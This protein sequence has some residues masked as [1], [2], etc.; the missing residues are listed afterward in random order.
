MHDESDPMNE[1]DHNEAMEAD[2]HPK[3]YVII[4]A[5][6]N[7]G[8]YERIAQWDMGGAGAVPELTVGNADGLRVGKAIVSRL[9]KHLHREGTVA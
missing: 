3:R 7:G 4:V 6:V 5:E 1:A 2:N 8:P 9:N